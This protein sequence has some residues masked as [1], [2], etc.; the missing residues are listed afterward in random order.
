[1]NAYLEDI[2]KALDKALCLQHYPSQVVERQSRPEIEFQ[3]TKAV[4]LAPITIART[5]N[6]RCFIERSINSVRVSIKVRQSDDIEK[7][8]CRKFAR[9]FM[10]RADNFI[11]LR[12]KAIEG[13]DISF[14]I[15]NTH[16]EELVKEK[17]IEFIISFMKDLDKQIKDLKI[18]MNS[19]CGPQLGSTCP[20]LEPDLEPSKMKDQRSKNTNDELVRLLSFIFNIPES[21]QM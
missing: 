12:R 21:P 13:Y 11:I 3:T 14:L 17:V 2:R 15:T 5:E 10:Q 7:M 1:M 6:E 19:D 16:L 20:N 8:L 4:L 18:A 9:F